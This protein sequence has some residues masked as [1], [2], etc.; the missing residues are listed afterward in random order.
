M[1]IISDIDTCI[2]GFKYHNKSKHVISR[3]KYTSN[4]VLFSINAEYWTPYHNLKYLD[5]TTLSST[6][7]YINVLRLPRKD[8][9]QNKN[10][11]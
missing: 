3:F 1:D 7:R 8:T 6:S 10:A 4:L 5:G 9:V 2:F 11:S